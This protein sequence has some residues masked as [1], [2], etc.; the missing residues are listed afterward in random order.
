MKAYRASSK[1]NFAATR[2]TPRAAAL[3]FFAA[4]PGK[5]KCNVIQG[6]V[7][8]PMFTVVYGRASLGQ[9]PDSWRDVTPKTVNTLPDEVT[10]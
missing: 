6:T 1:G 4:F 2:A 8:G 10:P 5:R 3:A 7:D 9:W